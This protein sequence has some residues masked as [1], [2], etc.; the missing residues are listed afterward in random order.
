[1]RTKQT[2]EGAAAK[3]VAPP[4]KDVGPEGFSLISNGKLMALYADLLKCRI[5]E[6]RSTSPP[7]RGK[8]NG[9]SASIRGYE[10]G[11]VGVAIDLGSDDAVC[12]PNRGVLKAFPNG[13]PIDSLLLWSGVGLESNGFHSSKPGLRNGRSAAKPDHIH[14]QATIGAALAHKTSKNGKVAIVFGDESASDSW[15]EALHIATVHALPMIFVLRKRGKP[16]GRS[17]TSDS[18]QVAKPDT[19][20]FP[21]IAVDSND[22]VAIYRVANEAISRARSGRGPTLIECRPFR[23][24]GT[25][26]G[27]GKHSHDPILTMENYLR[28]K[29]LFRSE[30]KDDILKTAARELQA[31]VKTSNGRVARSSH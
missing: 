13:A 31:L 3:A 20:W 14:T 9:T 15:R 17:R 18:K 1:M 28:A 30:T 16:A 26:N 8:T 10:A 19:P 11:I 6:E 21:S 24:S 25:F 12:S 7:G 2:R 4:G 23:L 5:I 27:N 29:G 22:V